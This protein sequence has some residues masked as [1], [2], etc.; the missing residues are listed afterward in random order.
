MLIGQ[1]SSIQF[2]SVMSLC[3][4]LKALTRLIRFLVGLLYINLYSKSTTSRSRWSWGLRPVPHWRCFVQAG[5][6]YLCRVA[7]N[8]VWSHTAGDAA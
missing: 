5:R 6:V 1:F 3:T 8:T 7:D 2:S 4:R